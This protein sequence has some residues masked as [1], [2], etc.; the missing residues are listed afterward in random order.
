MRASSWNRSAVSNEEIA[1]SYARFGNVW[2]V[3]E[4][5]G[6]SGQTISRRLR[7]AGI[8]VNKRWL[9]H[10][11]R[12]AI[13]Q[14]YETAPPETFTLDGL[15]AQLGRSKSL[16]ALEARKMGLTD[17]K[18]PN[19]AATRELMRKPKWNDKPHPRGM[20]GKKHTEEL[21]AQIG[22]VSRQR[23]AT[24]KAFG[25]GQM[26]P[27]CIKKRRE[28]AVKRSLSRTGQSEK[29]FSRARGSHRADLGGVFFRSSWEANFARYLNLLMKMKIVE[30]WEFE[31]HT[32]WFE[33]VKRGVV[34]YLPDFRIIYR[35]DPTPEYVEIKG[36]VTNKDRTKWRRMAKYHPT[37]KLVVIGEKEYRTIQNKWS[38]AIPEWERGDRKPAA[39][40]RLLGKEAPL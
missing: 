16:I 29:L 27:D 36:W 2:K 21:R 39:F 6:L 31:P 17:L 23:W 1:E 30:S 9:V 40:T 3:A 35:N 20:L 34:S 25:I 10:A 18:R 28:A 11:D 4:E 13:R 8:V 37:I 33:G 32:F 26:S 22:K 24:D 12:E 7:E 14:Y 5:V 19:S 38:S 15:A